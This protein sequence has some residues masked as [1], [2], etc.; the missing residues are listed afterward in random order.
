VVTIGTKRTAKINFY[1]TKNV[2]KVRRVNIK[3]IAGV[4]L[5]ITSVFGS[6]YQYTHCFPET[7]Q[8][9]R[10]SEETAWGLTQVV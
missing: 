10:V 7:I 3:I 6:P 5:N 2:E 4:I 8:A 9:K 1:L